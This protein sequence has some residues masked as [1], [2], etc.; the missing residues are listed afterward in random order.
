MRRLLLC[1][2]ASQNG[3]NLFGGNEKETKNR[4]PSA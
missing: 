1:G 3:E 2:T 4:K